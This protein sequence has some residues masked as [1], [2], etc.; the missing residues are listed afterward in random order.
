MKLEKT[1]EKHKNNVLEL[2]KQISSLE[3]LH[4]KE[5]DEK[6]KLLEKY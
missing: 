4:Q 5:V 3:L 6:N 2:K 1:I